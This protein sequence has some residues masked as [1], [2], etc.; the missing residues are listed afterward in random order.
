MFLE[1]IQNMT[2]IDWIIFAV[3]GIAY[4]ILM[5][6]IKIYN[7]VKQSFFTWL[8]WGILDSILTVITYQKGG[9]DLPIIAGCALGSFSIAIFLFIKKK[10]KWRKEERKT[11]CWVSA[12][13]TIWLLSGN[14]DIAIMSAVIAEIIA[15]IPLMRASWKKA[16]SLYTL[17]SYL[18]FLVSYILSIYSSPDWKI[19]NVSFPIAFLI[20][21]F[22]DTTPLVI[23]W[24]ILRNR[25]IKKRKQQ[26][27]KLA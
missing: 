17:I 10:R 6:D 8:L 7:G 9:S 11:L 22:G 21:S 23:K 4:Y 12:A 24:V 25:I 19:E 3:V 26:S 13:T 15:G 14:S 18:L 27:N 2:A 16:G 5:V 20:F 1:I